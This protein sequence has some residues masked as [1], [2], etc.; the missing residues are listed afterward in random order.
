MGIKASLNDGLV[1]YWPIIG[2]D[3]P[4]KD[5]SDYRKNLTWHSPPVNFVPGKYN[6]AYYLNTEYASDDS[7]SITDLSTRNEVSV[8]YWVC[9]L[10][11]ASTVFVDFGGGFDLRYD[12]SLSPPQLIFEIGSGN[13]A[14]T[15]G[16]IVGSWQ[17]VT[18]TYD[19]RM[20]HL[21]INGELASETPMQVRL[22]N[23]TAISLHSSGTLT[24]LD[25]VRIYDRALSQD[26]IKELM[27][28][29]M[30]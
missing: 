11:S 21:Y 6:S 9:L 3:N 26:E 25:E 22:S 20:I 30:E 8:S 23:P 18:G 12:V 17:Y 29:G 14:N 10:G 16:F 1:R 28:I 24:Y 13:S 4:Q 2:N 7:L 19:G 15:T 27:T 5:Y